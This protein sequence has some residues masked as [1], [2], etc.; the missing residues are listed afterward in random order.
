MTPFREYCSFV[1][2]L[3]LLCRTG[4]GLLAR[5]LLLFGLFLDYC[6]RACSARFFE[7]YAGIFG[8]GFDLVLFRLLLGLLRILV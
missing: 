3:I 8:E 2:R 5:A 7:V 1:H 4:L 6:L